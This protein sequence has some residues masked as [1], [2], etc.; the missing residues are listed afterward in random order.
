M[1]GGEVSA[2]T[3]ALSCCVILAE[4]PPPQKEG[5]GWLL[6][7]PHCQSPK[8][9]GHP[10]LLHPSPHHVTHLEWLQ[11][12]GADLLGWGPP[13]EGKP[14]QQPGDQACLPGCPGDRMRGLLGGGG[15]TLNLKGPHLEVGWGWEGK[16]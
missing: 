15:R 5:V 12:E 6:P 2:P 14:C 7:L 13:K 16:G 9:Q 3:L 11:E 10:L 1:L 8:F 4:L